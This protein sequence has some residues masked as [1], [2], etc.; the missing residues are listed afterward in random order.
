MV[1][2]NDRRDGREQAGSG[3]EERFG[4]AG[5]DS[6][7]ASGT[8]IAEAGESVDDAPNGAEEAD[9]GSDGTS[10][11]QP[12]HAF[13]RAADLV[14]R[15]DLHVGGDG[16]QAFEFRRMWISGCASHLAL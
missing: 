1:V 11:G 4:D 7:E 14:G 12:G 2:E 8:G 15:S 10:G 13:F 5:S 3:S 9:E 6:S 16:L